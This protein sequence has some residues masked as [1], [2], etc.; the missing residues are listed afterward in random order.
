MLSED[1]SVVADNN[2]LKKYFT[3]TIKLLSYNS[4]KVRIGVCRKAWPY[5][6]NNPT[7]IDTLFKA[8]IRKMTPYAREEQNRFGNTLT[9]TDHLFSA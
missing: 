8:Q 3:G 5:L 1:T 9:L 2:K 4:H 6:R 7:K